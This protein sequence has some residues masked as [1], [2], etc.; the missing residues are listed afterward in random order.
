MGLC[1]VIWGY[2][3]LCEIMWGG[4]SV[5]RQALALARVAPL[6]LCPLAR[7]SAYHLERWEVM[8]IFY[9]LVTE[10]LYLVILLF[11]ICEF[12]PGAPSMKFQTVYVFSNIT[13][14]GFVCLLLF[15]FTS[16]FTLLLIFSNCASLPRMIT[17]PSD[18]N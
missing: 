13:Q 8:V 11:N 7:V 5:M 17:I 15:L 14:T 10:W 6:L 18:L 3:R 2:A 9:I 4:P 16:V 12:L 1:E